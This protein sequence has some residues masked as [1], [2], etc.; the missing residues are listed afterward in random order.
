M[1]NILAFNHEIQ[2]MVDIFSSN[3]DKNTPNYKKLR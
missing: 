2:R 1:I 3:P